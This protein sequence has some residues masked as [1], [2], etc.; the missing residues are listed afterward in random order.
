MS[1]FLSEALRLP[2]KLDL[3]RPTL[4][5][6]VSPHWHPCHFLS[7]YNILHQRTLGRSVNHHQP[8][9]FQNPPINHDRWTSPPQCKA[10]LS[11][12]SRRQSVQSM[13]WLCILCQFW[14]LVLVSMFVKWDS[15]LFIL[16]FPFVWDNACWYLTTNWEGVYDS[17]WILELGVCRPWRSLSCYMYSVPYYAVI[18]MGGS[19]IHHGWDRSGWRIL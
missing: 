9:K 13:T 17:L 7:M 4:Q 1:S 18:I 16:C 8:I 6:K 12:Y 5:K 11:A 19:I 2:K 14:V 10:A 3:R 15:G